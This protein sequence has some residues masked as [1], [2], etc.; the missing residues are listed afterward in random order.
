M[1]TTDSF[2]VRADSNFGASIL[3]TYPKANLP[4]VILG[5]KQG[6]NY[7]GSTLWYKIISEANGQEA[8]IHSKGVK[9]LN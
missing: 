6:E 5:E 9:P 3:F 8:Y 2:K 7:E 1:A 4:I